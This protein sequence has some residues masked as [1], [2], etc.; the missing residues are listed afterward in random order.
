MKKLLLFVILPMLSFGQLSEDY[1]IFIEKETSNTIADFNLTKGSSVFI[2]KCEKKK[3]PVDVSKLANHINNSLIEC[4][5]KPIKNSENADYTIEVVY[6]SD[7]FN[8]RQITGLW[9]EMIDKNQN[10]VLG[11]QYDK[12]LKLKKLLLH[13]K[14]V[15]EYL[16]YLLTPKIK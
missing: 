13:P 7:I 1:I 3:K 4:G 5:L 16:K 2:K 10:I 9:L 15:G 6:T 12:N 11:W 8:P 14:D